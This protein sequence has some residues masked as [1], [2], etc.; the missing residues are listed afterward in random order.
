MENILHLLVS[1]QLALKCFF[2]YSRKKSY[3]L[4]ALT[5]RLRALEESVKHVKTNEIIVEENDL[6]KLDTCDQRYI[7]VHH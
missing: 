4:E 5:F 6:K 1:K 3:E 2:A 7:P